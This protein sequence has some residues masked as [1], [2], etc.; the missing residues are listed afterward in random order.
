MFQALDQRLGYADVPIKRHVQVAG[1]KS[2]FDGNWVYWS[3]RLQ[4]YPLLTFR[5]A[6]LLKKQEGKCR[7]CRLY[8]KQG[9]MIEIDHKSHVVMA[10]GMNTAIF[11]C[12]MFIAM[13][14]RPQSMELSIQLVQ[15]VSMSTITLS[16]SRVRS[17][18]S[19][20]V[21]KTRRSGDRMS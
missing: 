18:V 17:K 1:T 11:N 3:K 8:F 5:Q 10:A 21:L 9:D 20:T 13:M 7:W 15:T 16:R 2:P 12:F 14:K 6:K 19:R 4:H